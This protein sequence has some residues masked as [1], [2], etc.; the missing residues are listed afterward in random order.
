MNK[1]SHISVV[2]GQQ[3]PGEGPVENTEVSTQPLETETEELSED[4]FVEEAEWYEEDTPRRHRGW[5]VPTLAIIVILGWT[6][7]FGWTNQS[8]MLAGA[9]PQQWIDWI[10]SWAV[11]VLLVVGF[12]ILATRNSAHEAKR[13]GEVAR[14]LSEESQN[15]ENRLAV[16]NRELSLAR[17]FLGSQTRD[18][19]YLGRSATERISENADRLQELI[20]GNGEQV[21]AIASVSQT[22]LENMSSLRDDLPVIASSAK[23]VTNRIGSA[24]REAKEQVDALVDSFAQLE[25][26]GERSEQRIAA[27]RGSVDTAMTAFSEQAGELEKLAEERFAALRE[28]S[29]AFREEL[30]GQEIE[31]LAALNARSI[32]LRSEIA[33]VHKQASADEELALATMRERIGTL[34]NEAMEIARSVREGEDAAMG[35]WSTQIDAMRT[36]L[37]EAI[38]EIRQIDEAALEAA[39]AKLAALHEEAARVDQ[40]ITERNR[41]FENETQQRTDKMAEAQDA[42][43]AKLQEKLAVLDEAIAE[44][45]EAQIAQIATLT[46]EGEALGERIGALGETFSNIA[47]HGHQAREA[48]AGGIDALDAQLRESREALEGTDRDIARL[49][50]SSVRL[51]ELI[52]ASAKHSKDDLPVAMEASENRLAEIEQR[53]GEVRELLE[54]ARKTGDALTEGMG[55]IEERT[56]VAMEGFDTFQSNFGETASAQINSVERLRAGLVELSHESTQLAAHVQ[57]ELR[58]AIGQ[59]EDKARAS[60]AGIEQEQ[61]HRIAQISDKV[62]EE[63]IGAVEKA[64]TDKTQDAIAQLDEARQRSNEAARAMTQQLRDQLGRLNDLTTNLETRIA[65][66]RDKATDNVDSDFARRV[67]LITESLNSSSIDIAKALSSEVTDTAWA[68]YL[69]GD[70]GIFTRR[71]VRLIDNSEARDIAELYDA[72]ADFR[73][74]VNRYIHDFEAM[75]RTLLSTRDGNAVSVTLLSSDMGKLYVVLAQAL[76]RLRQ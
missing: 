30:H 31:A 63:S 15:L 48:V 8:E 53:A 28:E 71:A 68:S 4:E 60:L 55:S 25:E 52:Q 41:L 33:E 64:L 5:I 46:E 57:G 3:A 65:H 67:A 6:G 35:A 44:R 32:T 72:D 7:F 49:T 66:A 73:E 39:N 59:L 36:R 17:E 74:H 23:D 27:V 37:T 1:R 76:E 24:G 19:E 42:M 11:P 43:L 21:D 69:R 12:W 10:T 58:D 34:R 54:Q 14:T 26:H 61:A 70:R 50:D 29:A 51:L 2:E 13:F 22:A 75:L 9:G 16:V 40:R 62:G 20:R 38:D 56:R 47:A 45:R 18:L